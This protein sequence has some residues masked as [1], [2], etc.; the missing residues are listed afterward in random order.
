MKYLLHT[1]EL[2]KAMYEKEEAGLE[3][4]AREEKYRVEFEALK[5]I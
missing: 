3:A 5:R 1:R 4:L 2:A